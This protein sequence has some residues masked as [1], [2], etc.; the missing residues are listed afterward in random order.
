[1]PDPTQAFFARLVERGQQPALQ[2]TSGSIR[3]DID[4][5]GKV[6]HWRLDIRGGTVEVSHSGEAADCVIGT[7]AKLFDELATG[8]ANAMAAA[9]RNELT[10]EGDPG[11]LVRFQRLF[12]APIGRRVR[13]SARTVGKRRG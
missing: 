3:I 2:R 10:I 8:K 9:L 12:P 5:D 7:P 13:S 11:F 1:M 4:R 6:A